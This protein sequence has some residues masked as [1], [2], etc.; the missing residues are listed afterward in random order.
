MYILGG[1]GD[2]RGGG[3]NRGERRGGGERRGRG[4]FGGKVINFF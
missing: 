4:G 3:D 1:R 2:R